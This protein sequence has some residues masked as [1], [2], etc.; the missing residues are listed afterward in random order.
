MQKTLVFS[1]SP[2][3]LVRARSIL[4]ALNSSLKEIGAKG[5]FV[6]QL[7]SE[8]SNERVVATSYSTGKIVIQGTAKGVGEMYDALV[9][10][11]GGGN[12][13]EE[14]KGGKIGVNNAFVPHIG[15]DEAG[16]GDYFGPVVIGAAFV[17]TEDQVQKLLKIGVRDSKKV[18]DSQALKLRDDI[19]GVVNAFSEI[20]IDPVQY[21]KLY[22]EFNNLNKLIAWGHA[23]SIEEIL[24]DVGVKRCNKAV[25]D[26]FAKSESRILD[27]LLSNGQKIEIEQ[28]HRGER[29]IAVAAASILAR[30]RFLTEMKNL[31]KKYGLNFPK[32][33][34]HVIGFGKEFYK[35]YGGDGLKK[36][37]K[38]PFK[39]TLK[40]TSTFDI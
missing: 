3:S 9:K 31:G 2:Q 32:G 16:K 30:G 14:S 21:G 12:N 28:M 6:W 5:N 40:I 17:E 7:K 19:Q 33:A 18:S 27:A 25:I 8:N 23:S 13:I 4:L 15:V 35:N 36:V 39:T 10:D 26:Q 34:S 37:A 24:E 11:F 22:K 29:D 20:V 38:I 1:I